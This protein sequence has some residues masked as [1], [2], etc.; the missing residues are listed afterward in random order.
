MFG[1]FR[2]KKKQA[3]T[4]SRIGLSRDAAL[5][6]LV[7]EIGKMSNPAMVF[8]FFDETR[9][10]FKG[11]MERKNVSNAKLVNARKISTTSLQISDNNKIYCIDHYPIASIFRSFKE[12]VA[13]ANQSIE[14]VVYGGLDEPIFDVFGGERVRGMISRLGMKPD[15]MIDHGMVAKSI[16]NA[17]EKIENKVI[18]ESLTDSS[19]E[20]FKRNLPGT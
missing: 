6:A 5:N 11:V 9:D 15:E 4:T 17:Q 2:S 16:Q 10:T 18:T 13:E 19:R 20:W 8:Y 1:L 12:A 3:K 14:I 7:N